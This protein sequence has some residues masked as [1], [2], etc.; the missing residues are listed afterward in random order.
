[1]KSIVTSRTIDIPKGVKIK[2]KS[3][4]IQIWG[5]RGKLTRDFRHILIDIKIDEEKKKLF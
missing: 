4:V 2:K 5:P 1:M 3:R